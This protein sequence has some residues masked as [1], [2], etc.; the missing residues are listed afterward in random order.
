MTHYKYLGAV[1]TPSMSSFKHIQFVCSDALRK[2]GY[3]RWRLTK[4]PKETTLL[5]Y[6]SLIHPILEYASWV[7]NPH[8]WC[9]ND[10]IEAI[11]SKVMC[12]IYR[13]YDCDFSPSLARGWELEL[14]YCF[15]NSL[16]NK[17]CLTFAEQ[18]RAWSRH[19]LNIAPF[20]THYNS[21][22]EFST[23]YNSLYVIFWIP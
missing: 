10:A 4:A 8:K 11:R 18:S 15:I 22:L 17:S 1:F 23:W 9:E 3:L 7:W 12:F 21:S 5:T 19:A 14:L 20:Y 6:K 16:S 2:L 13:Q